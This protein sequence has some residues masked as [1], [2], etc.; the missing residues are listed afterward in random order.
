MRRVVSDFVH[1]PQ[2]FSLYS[3]A[4]YKRRILG[5]IFKMFFFHFFATHCKLFAPLPAATAGGAQPKHDTDSATAG[6]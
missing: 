3:A 1:P 2:D 4:L 6:E 5:N